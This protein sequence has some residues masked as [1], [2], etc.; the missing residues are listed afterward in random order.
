MSRNQ[1]GEMNFRGGEHWAADR[2]VE[3]H[4]ASQLRI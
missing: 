3:F 2:R 1:V 4:E